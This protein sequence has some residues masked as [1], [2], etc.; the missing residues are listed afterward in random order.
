M[1]VFRTPDGRII[2]EK[3][4]VPSAR[5]TR[6]DTAESSGRSGT[7]YEAPT[8]VRRPGAEGGGGPAA[9]PPVRPGE[10]P[11]RLAGA[12]PV[13]ATGEGET[14]PVSGWLV[15]IDGPGKGHDVRIGVGRNGVGR[16]EGNR[17]ALPFGDAL[18][19]RRAHLWVTY[20]QLHRAFSVSPGDSG[21]NLAYLDGEAID[22]RM[23]LGHGATISVG[24]TTLRF[25]AFC[26]EGF[27]W[28]DAG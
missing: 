18:I 6:S 7:G 23:P 14:D 5:R 15:V 3:T 2:E 24:E 12:I 13:S 20:D 16:D 22:G 26:G 19:S 27:D 10:E 11:T 8:L 28:T 17:V 21:T 25:V 4:G 1:P 9:R